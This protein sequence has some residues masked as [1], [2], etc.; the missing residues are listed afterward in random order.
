MS[1]SKLAISLAI[2]VSIVLFA[3]N[4]SILAT[5]Q[6]EPQFKTVA[7]LETFFLIPLDMPDFTQA[8]YVKDGSGF[9]F[10]MD[11]IAVYFSVPGEGTQSAFSIL[12]T[13]DDI[14]LGTLK[15]LA[16]SRYEINT[17]ENVTIETY[18]VFMSDGVPRVVLDAEAVRIFIFDNEEA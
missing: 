16:M 7:Y 1:L 17:I 2:L 13:V 3:S 12:L 5:M 6:R 15:V 8:P 9:V 18:W 14:E 11:H 10:D 4:C